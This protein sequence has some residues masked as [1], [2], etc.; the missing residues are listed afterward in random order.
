MVSILKYFDLT[1]ATY[2]GNHGHRA[3]EF[4]YKPIVYS[5]F[6]TSSLKYAWEK[7]RKEAMER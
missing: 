7:L 4:Q 3:D 6:I 2:S 1:R 5:L